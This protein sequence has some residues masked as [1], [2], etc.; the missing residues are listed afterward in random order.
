MTGNNEQNDGWENV[1]SDVGGLRRR[2]LRCKY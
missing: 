2:S 1:N